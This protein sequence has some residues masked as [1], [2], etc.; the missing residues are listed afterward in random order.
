M[1]I[2]RVA[3]G[4]MACLMMSLLVGCANQ[5]LIRGQ[6]PADSASASNLPDA[7]VVEAPAVYG[8]SNSAVPYAEYP[9]PYNNRLAH[10]IK[11][12]VDSKL[13]PDDYSNCYKNGELPTW[14]GSAWVYADGTPYWGWGPKHHFSFNYK[15]PENLV[16]PSPSPTPAGMTMY[17]YYTLKGPD[18]FFH[19]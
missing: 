6:S 1:M 16:Y 10:E 5:S 2:T 13:P 19:Q 4:L 12:R 3:S 14:N 8:G 9:F 15:V 11:N 18:C 7:T 17:P